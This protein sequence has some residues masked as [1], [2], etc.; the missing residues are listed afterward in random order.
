MASALKMVALASLGLPTGISTQNI[1]IPAV[2]HFKLIAL[3]PS[4]TSL[5]VTCIIMLLYL[6]IK[7][8][9]LVEYCNYAILFYT[10]F[11]RGVYYKLV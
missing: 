2:I 8:V 3:G 1:H 10:V 9:S 6:Q 5:S 11:Q 4:I 7:L